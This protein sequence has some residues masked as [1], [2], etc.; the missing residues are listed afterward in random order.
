MVLTHV[1]LHLFELSVGLLVL[2]GVLEVSAQHLLTTGEA[3]ELDCHCCDY[4]DDEDQDVEGWSE[5][6]LL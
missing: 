3:D 1:I 2:F 6:V 4:E 5:L